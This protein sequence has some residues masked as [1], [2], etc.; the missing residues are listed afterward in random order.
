MIDLARD[1]LGARVDDLEGFESMARRLVDAQAP[2][3]ARWVRSLAGARQE[4]LVLA[5]RLGALHLLL[6]S[7][8]RIDAL[9]EG[10]AAD[11]RGLIGFTTQKRDVLASGERVKDRWWVLGSQVEGEDELTARRTWLL[12]ERT[13][14]MGMILDFA[15]PGGALSVGLPP[16]DAFDVEVAFYPS[17]SP[18]RCLLVPDGEEGPKP[19]GRGSSPALGA[20]LLPLLEVWEQRRRALSRQPWLLRLGVG[21]ADLTPVRLDEGR[22]GVRCGAGGPLLR[23]RATREAVY[24]LVAVGGG[25]P[26]GV[27]GELEDDHLVPLAAFTDGHLSPLDSGSAL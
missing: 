24:G 23:L 14:R 22:F 13:G 4:P 7:Y 5:R 6:E 15:P 16:G 8:A 17:A 21:L 19:V 9:P 25:G 11:V 12:G 1:G 2:G 10:L 27:F 18:S 20:W 26:V 3:L